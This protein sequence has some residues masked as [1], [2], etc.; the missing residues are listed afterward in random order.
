MTHG[1][2]HNTSLLWAAAIGGG[3][4][5]FFVGRGTVNNSSALTELA[6]VLAL[7]HRVSTSTPILASCLTACA[8]RSS[9][10]SAAPA[11]LPAKLAGTASLNPAA[12]VSMAPGRSQTARPSSTRAPWILPRDWGTVMHRKT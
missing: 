6:E 5:G 8:V 11:A 7:Q 12:A 9:S 4:L 2:K 1:P 10:S 3:L